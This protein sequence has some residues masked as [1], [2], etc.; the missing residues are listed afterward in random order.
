[1]SCEPRGLRDYE[2]VVKPVP[3]GQLRPA[4]LD[5]VESVR[6]PR[7]GVL[8]HSSQSLRDFR[9]TAHLL[10]CLQRGPHSKSA[11]GKQLI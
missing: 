9:D 5:Q 8:V 3:K 11:H 10:I 7:I 4:L 6:K 1:M 2:D